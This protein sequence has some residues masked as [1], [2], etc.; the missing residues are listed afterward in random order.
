VPP[1]RIRT[2]TQAPEADPV[3]NSYL[4]KHTLATLA[5]GRMGEEL[6]WVIPSMRTECAVS[7]NGQVTAFAQVS[8]LGKDTITAFE[9]V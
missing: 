2:C 6:V 8:G 1:G 4:P 7:Q 9:T 3:C 5:G